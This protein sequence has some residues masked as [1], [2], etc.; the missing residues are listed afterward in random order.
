M[1]Y[2]LPVCIEVPRQEQD[3]CVEFTILVRA[4]QLMSDLRQHL[5]RRVWSTLRGMQKAKVQTLS[6]S[7]RSLSSNVL[8]SVMRPDPLTSLTPPWLL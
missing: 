2:H 5:R 7:K 8:S 6:S 3:L 4:K 1:Y